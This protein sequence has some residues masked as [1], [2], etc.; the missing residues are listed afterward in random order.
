MNSGTDDGQG[1]AATFNTIYSLVYNSSQSLLYVLDGGKIRTVTSGGDV[2][3]LVL[4]DSSG[5][6]FNFD[7]A[8]LLGMTWNGSD[9]LYT[10]DYSTGIIY[11]ISTTAV[12]GKH[13]VT[14]LLTLPSP[15]VLNTLAYGGGFLY[16]SDR[17]NFYDLHKINLTNN[18]IT[19]LT[20]TSGAALTAYVSGSLYY[21]DTTDIYILSGTDGSIIAGNSTPDNNKTII[22]GN[23][24]AAGFNMVSGITFIGST[25]YVS[26]RDTS[27][28][29]SV[30]TSSPYT[31]ATYAIAEI[32]VPTNIVS[33]ITDTSAS[34]SWNAPTTTN[35]LSITG[36]NIF[37]DLNPSKLV[38]LTT[39]SG[40]SSAIFTG[41]SPGT[42]YAFSISAITSTILGAFSNDYIT[43]TGGGGGGAGD[44]YVTTFSKISYK[45]PTINGA[46]RYFQTMEARKLLTINVQLKTVER[47]EMSDDTFRS[48]LTLKNKV[49]AKQFAVLA[50]KLAEPE[51]L[52]FFEKVSIQHGN[53]RLVVNLW[54]SRFELVENSLRC[55]VEKV[56]RPDLLLKAGGIYNGYTAQTLKLTIGKT[57]VFLSTFNSP[58]V[59]NGISIETGSL[60]GANGVIVNALSEKAM[61]LSSL[62]STEP[63]ATR[64]SLKAVTKVET[65]IDHEG[66]RTR[67]V[68]SYR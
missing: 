22:N 59:R 11:T 37:S 68:I 60:K 35:G 7:D 44:P 27:S 43:T 47:E 62:D 31:V 29:R 52:C 40:T 55:G 9:T 28:I 48:M 54:N 67:N 41:L 1:A 61:V 26:D 33:T 24:T 42:A 65:F 12:S 6:D 32:S 36:Y 45:L 8:E 16:V 50:A 21:T 46:V 3:T 58:M 17:S 34:I 56:N 57:A 18:T 10:G 13:E 23:G 63:V 49:S 53:Q 4:D 5:N 51:T 30:G 14:Q 39:V 2:T 15:K 19:T 64:D 25:L 20:L 38:T 66:V